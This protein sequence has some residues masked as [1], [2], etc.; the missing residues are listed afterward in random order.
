VRDI[1]KISPNT[2]F[3][4]A[5]IPLLINLIYLLL[6]ISILSILFYSLVVYNEL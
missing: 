6:T 3:L 4:P 1:Y 5:L 2:N